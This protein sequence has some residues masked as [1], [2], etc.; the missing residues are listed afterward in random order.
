MTVRKSTITTST[1]GAALSDSDLRSP[2]RLPG[3]PVHIPKERFGR[4]HLQMR[5]KRY[6]M[7]TVLFAGLAGGLALNLAMLFTFRL[8]GFGANGEGP[9]LD[10]AWQSPKL[11][12]VWTTLHPR[13]LIVTRPLLTAAGLMCFALIHAAIYKIVRDAW[14]PKARSRTLRLAAL[15]L[16]QFAFWE[17]FTPL[18]LLGEPLFLVGL[19]LLFWAVIALSEAVAIVLVFRLLDRRDVQACLF[20]TPRS[21]P[22]R[23]T[24][25][26]V[27]PIAQVS[28]RVKR[29]ID[30]AENRPGNP[31]GVGGCSRP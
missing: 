15:L 19:E 12:A 11:I 27:D 6:A 14:P 10:P 26:R 13:P 7:T 23:K 4:S 24:L 3:P 31:G 30:G 9:L 28:A 16:A 8:L 17:F 21:A 20:S 5:L 25:L 22:N 2:A 29:M 18:S 1:A